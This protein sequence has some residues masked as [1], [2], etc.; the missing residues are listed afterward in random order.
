MEAWHMA[1]SRIMVKGPNLC[2]RETGTVPPVQTTPHSHCVQGNLRTLIF[3]VLATFRLCIVGT[4]VVQTFF[5]V[6]VQCHLNT[7]AF[8]SDLP[9]LF[10]AFVLGSTVCAFCNFKEFHGNSTDCRLVAMSLRGSCRSTYELGHS[11]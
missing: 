10:C 5:V 4:V 7:Y 11:C 1:G 3:S 6:F 2:R 8:L 9:H